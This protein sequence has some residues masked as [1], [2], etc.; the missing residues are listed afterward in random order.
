MHDRGVPMPDHKPAKQRA[1]QGARPELPYSQLNFWL[2]IKGAPF[3]VGFSLSRL[4]PGNEKSTPLRSKPGAARRAR[5]VP[6]R[7][8][9]SRHEARRAVTLAGG[10]LA[11]ATK[12]GLAETSRSF[13]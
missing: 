13:H 8:C 9:G 10:M 2:T 5:G 11:A 4:A 1:M 3:R 6:E 7:A 12:A